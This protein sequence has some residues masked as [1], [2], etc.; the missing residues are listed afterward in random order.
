VSQ[1]SPPAPRGSA[2]LF[3]AGFVAVLAACLL[4]GLAARELLRE[5]GL[6]WASIA[7]SAVAVVLAV[8]AVLVP[9]RSSRS[10]HS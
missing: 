2:L 5:N 8:A 3:A 7:S 6:L 1:A 9:G 10:S 4:F